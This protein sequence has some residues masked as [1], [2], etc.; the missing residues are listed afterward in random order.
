[1]RTKTNWKRTAKACLAIIFLVVF[2]TGGGPK[3]VIDLYT[4]FAAN[5]YGTVENAYTFRFGGND[6]KA[7]P[8]YNYRHSFLHYLISDGR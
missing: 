2:T 6:W 4:V 3:T 8:G 1:M 5:S 7:L